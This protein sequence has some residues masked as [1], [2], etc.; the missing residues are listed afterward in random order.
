M[1]WARVSESEELFRCILQRN[2]SQLLKVLDSP[3]ATGPLAINSQ[4]DG[5]GQ[6][7]EHIL[8]GTLNINCIQAVDQSVEMGNFISALKYPISK[9]IGKTVGES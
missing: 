2:K 9:V 3:F 8:D 5:S 6:A 7:T 1:A 4:R